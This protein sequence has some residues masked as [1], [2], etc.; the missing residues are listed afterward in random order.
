MSQK[1]VGAITEGF[2]VSVYVFRGAPRVPCNFADESAFFGYNV[3]CVLAR[4]EIF[5]NRD[6]S[7]LATAAFSS[8]KLLSRA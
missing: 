1:G 8:M 6:L 2:S 3:V 7:F 4:S 5:G